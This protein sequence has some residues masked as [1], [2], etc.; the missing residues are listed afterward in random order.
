M[1][2]KTSQVIRTLVPKQPAEGVFTIK[3]QFSQVA[4]FD[5]LNPFNLKLYW[6]FP[7]NMN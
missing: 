7:L 4:P 3:T 5:I 1:D 6:A 2:L